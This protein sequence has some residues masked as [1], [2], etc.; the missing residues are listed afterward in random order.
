MAVGPKTK[1]KDI[2]E[3]EVALQG[4]EAIQ[5]LC[6]AMRPSILEATIEGIIEELS[7]VLPEVDKRA[8][9]LDGASMGE[10]L[11]QSF[12]EAL[13]VSA[14]GWADDDLAFVTD[15]GFELAEIRVPVSLWQ[16]DA[17]RMVPFSHGQWLAA[18]LPQDRVQ[19]H[20]LPG[21]GHISIRSHMGEM[22]DEVLQAAG[23]P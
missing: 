2:E 18:H 23:R 15:W 9:L 4:G 6:R 11:V 19:A 5:K 14:D 8:L 17:D 12:H 13:R 21:E 22:L 1:Q 3:F 7:T 10:G 20:L 16:G